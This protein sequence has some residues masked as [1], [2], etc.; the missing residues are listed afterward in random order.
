MPTFIHTQHKWASWKS[1][2]EQL[3]HQTGAGGMSVI[4]H[5]LPHTQNKS[6]RENLTHSDTVR[7]EPVGW[8]AYKNNTYGGIRTKQLRR[9]LRLV[10]EL[11]QGWLF[12]AL[13]PA[14]LKWAILI[15]LL[16][17]IPNWAYLSSVQAHTRKHHQ[18]EER[19][20]QPHLKVT[21]SAPTSWI[22]T[23]L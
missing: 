6:S 3:H 12:H 2:Y 16:D 1:A 20:N 13:L 22:K 23:S 4:H 11:E 15:P 19:S 17:S 8:D 18:Q 14:P 5:M 21:L 9:Q 10:F 7:Q